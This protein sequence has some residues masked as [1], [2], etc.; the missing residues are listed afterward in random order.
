MVVLA[1]CYSGSRHAEKTNR[2]TKRSKGV[3]KEKGRKMKEKEKEKG[4]EE[5]LRRR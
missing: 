1:V 2:S 3:V 5:V 4:D